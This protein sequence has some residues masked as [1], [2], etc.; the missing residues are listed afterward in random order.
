MKRMP[1]RLFAQ[2]L[3][4]EDSNHLQQACKVTPGEADPFVFAYL[5][6][7]AHKFDQEKEDLEVTWTEACT[8][9]F[10]GKSPEP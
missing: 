10:N 8:S 2:M 1:E 5:Y 7:R 4:I 6:E 9:H 3:D